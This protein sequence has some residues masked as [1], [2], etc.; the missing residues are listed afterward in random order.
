MHIYVRLED[1]MIYTNNRKNL[2]SMKTTTLLSLMLAVLPAAAQNG[3]TKAQLP[4]LH[5][6][7]QRDAIIDT[8]QGTL[9]NG[10]YRQSVGYFFGTPRNADG[11]AGTYVVG[12]DKVTYYIQN[13]FSQFQSGTWVKATLLGDTLYMATPQPVYSYTDDGETIH[14]Y[15]SNMK[16]D[17]E[18][19]TFV[20]DTENTT[21]KFVVRGDT[22]KQVS[23][24]LLGM[25]GD[26]GE[27]MLYG[28]CDLKIFRNRDT[29]AEAPATL[30]TQRYALTYNDENGDRQSRLV[31]L[32]FDGN[33]VW[34]GQLSDRFPTN[35]VKGEKG[36]DRIVF[37]NQQY[38]GFKDNHHVYFTTGEREEATDPQTGETGEVYVLAP[39]IRF[40]LDGDGYKSDGVMFTN[41]GKKDVNF[42]DCYEQP[43]LEK[44]VE[45]PQTPANPIPVDFSPYDSDDKY[46]T[47]SFILPSLSTTGEV[48]NPDRLYYNIYVDERL[49][50]FKATRYGLDE[51]MTD[52][53]YSFTDGHTFTA[54]TTHSHGRIVYFKEKVGSY[55]SHIGVRA[56]YRG[57]GESHGSDIVYNDG[58]V[59]D[60]ITA[61]IYSRQATSVSYFDL[62]GR[63]VNTTQKGVIIKRETLPDGTVRYQKVSVK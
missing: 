18:R 45:T 39:Q 29:V 60:T 25:T 38:F 22:L 28:D 51:D 59:T 24:Q 1:S 56:I 35:W 15:L 63:R 13:I 8:P 55:Y 32:G 12:N 19:Q 54:S 40:D 27:W 61:P 42:R 2:M 36:K 44:F 6:A 23:P 33:D 7:A 17:D 20:T 21:A 3:I 11:I 53:P 16:Y 14:I 47:F 57:A 46:G 43:R 5:M 30:T 49:L 37:E 58:E 26:S 9:H 41:W 34:L 10:L 48:L 52:I 50:T 4:A 31:K 62:T